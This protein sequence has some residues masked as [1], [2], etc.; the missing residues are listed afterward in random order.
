MIGN[1]IFYSGSQVF[2]HAAAVESTP[3]RDR[4]GEARCGGHGGR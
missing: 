1:V 2:G 4:A 3:L